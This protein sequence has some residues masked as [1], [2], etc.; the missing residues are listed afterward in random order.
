MEFWPEE[1]S[2]SS[3]L[4]VSLNKCFNPDEVQLVVKE[5]TGTT[6]DLTWWAFE[7]QALPLQLCFFDEA[8][9][10]ESDRHPLNIPTQ[11]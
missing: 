4:A 8:L 3:F 11:G 1:D 5:A 7:A 10:M 2:K 9:F 6:V